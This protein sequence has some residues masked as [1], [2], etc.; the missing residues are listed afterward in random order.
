MPVF[1]DELPF[2]GSTSGVLD[3]PMA[4]QLERKQTSEFI[5]KCLASVS[6]GGKY[7]CVEA[8]IF[9]FLMAGMVAYKES[10]SVYT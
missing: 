2:P 6:E 7:L 4:K 8:D 1:F 10:V 9:P 3:H 5:I